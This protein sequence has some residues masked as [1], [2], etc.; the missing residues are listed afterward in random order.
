MSYLAR[1]CMP[2]GG[3][4]VSEIIQSVMSTIYFG[5]RVYCYRLFFMT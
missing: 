4:S 5:D 1:Q 3:D 2:T